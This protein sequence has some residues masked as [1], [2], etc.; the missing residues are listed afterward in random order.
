MLNQPQ[1]IGQ[2]IKLAMEAKGV[3]PTEVGHAFGVKAPSVNDWISTGRIHKKHLSKLVT[4]FGQPLEWWLDGNK[5]KVAA[6]PDHRIAEPEPH[7]IAERLFTAD[8]VVA[9]W[10]QLNPERQRRMITN[11]H[12]LLAAQKAET[13]SSTN[14]YAQVAAPAAG[15]TTKKPDL[16][17]NK[18]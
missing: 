8:D 7:Y 5:T 4:Y 6:K 18:P 16:K 12:D 10:K 11:A 15:P 14:P 2:R 9:I 3:G 17:R 13:P 1:H